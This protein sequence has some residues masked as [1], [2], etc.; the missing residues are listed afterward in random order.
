MES[1]FKCDLQSI[2]CFDGQTVSFERRVALPFVP[3]VGL[4]LLSKLTTTA[5]DVI[6]EVCWI[7]GKDLFYCITRA[8]NLPWKKNKT[9][10]DIVEFYE[11]LGWSVIL[12]ET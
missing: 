6:E 12:R 9:M 2:V 11:S 5:R 10:D 8:H 7:E 4:R 3:F 1:N